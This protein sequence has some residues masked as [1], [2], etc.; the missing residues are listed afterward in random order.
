ME[1]KAKIIYITG[2]ERSG[3]SSYARQRA[4]QLS[5]KPVYLATAQVKDAEFAARV[6]RHKAA[7]GDQWQLIEKP[8]AISG[9]KLE[10][11][12]VV[13]DCIT[14]W[15]TNIFFREEQD[16]EKSL[17]WAKNEWDK[18]MNQSMYCIV[19]SNELGMG[20]H[21]ERQLTRDF[22][23][24]QGWMNQ[25]ISATADEAWLMVSGIPLRLK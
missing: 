15:L 16:K 18:F 11:R 19:V 9:M 17:A 7:R 8:F 10:D 22:V 25:H 12:V 14:L 20:V 24:L 1:K 13:L 6:A 3:K 2:G 21:G 4:L 5:D 23:E